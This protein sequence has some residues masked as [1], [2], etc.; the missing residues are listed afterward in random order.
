MIENIKV[1]INGK[2]AL[3]QTP[4]KKANEEMFKQITKLLVQ[5]NKKFEQTIELVFETREKSLVQELKDEVLRDVFKLTKK[6]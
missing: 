5:L 6:K 3:K 1:R 4:A 2:A